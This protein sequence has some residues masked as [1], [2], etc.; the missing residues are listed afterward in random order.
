MMSRLRFVGYRNK[1]ES[2]KQLKHLYE[3]AFPLEERIPF[4]LLK[5]LTRGGKGE[6][7]GV[8]DQDELAGMIYNVYH[9]DI[10]YVSYF[11]VNDAKRGCGYGSRI[12]QVIQKKYSTQ[13]IFL[14]IEEMDPHAENYDQ[15]VKR[16]A[17]Y[18]RNGFRM[19]DFQVSEGTIM[20]DAMCVAD[21]EPELTQEE[22]EELMRVYFG[23]GRIVLKMK[24][25][26]DP[27][28][29]LLKK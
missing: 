25:Y 27:I 10:V 9:K 18:E 22:C 12:L 14:C 5:L 13:R 1:K 29:G 6:F 4:W 2:R 26:T 7:Y 17:F 3:E 8:Y 20:Y 15:R 21:R 19:M 23:L 16:K 11:A 24:K 28:V